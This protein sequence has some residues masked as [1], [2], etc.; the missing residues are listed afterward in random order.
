MGEVRFGSFWTNAT[1]LWL[2]K[3]DLEEI[4]SKTSMFNLTSSANF[5]EPRQSCC[6]CSETQDLFFSAA[7]S[8][9]VAA[10]ELLC[11][12]VYSLE[13]NMVKNCRKHDHGVKPRSWRQRRDTG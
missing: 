5:M 3:E 10:L 12:H 8:C 6:H 7:L 9:S 4:M 1:T 13:L 2:S 11:I